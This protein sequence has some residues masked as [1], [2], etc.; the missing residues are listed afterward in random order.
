MAASAVIEIFVVVAMSRRVNPR[1]LAGLPEAGTDI[2]G[3]L[4]HVKTSREMTPV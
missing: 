3:Y 4:V 2:R 1:C